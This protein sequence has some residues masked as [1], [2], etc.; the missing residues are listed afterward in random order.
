MES[1]SKLTPA[2]KAERKEMLANLPRG[3]TIGNDGER[4]TVLCV[5]DGAVTRVFSSVMGDDET[6]FRRKVG[7]YHA[8]LRYRNGDGGMI[9]PGNDW[10]ATDVIHTLGDDW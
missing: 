3:S 4:F 8:L 2:Q 5:P 6:K 9:L 10:S 1:N 7:E